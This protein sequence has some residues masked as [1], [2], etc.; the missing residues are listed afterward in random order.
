MSSKITRSRRQCR[1]G[2]GILSWC[3]SAAMW[4]LTWF[5]IT[6]S[7]L[8]SCLRSLSDKRV[9]LMQN[10]HYSLWHFRG[11]SQPGAG[12]EVFAIRL[13]DCDIG[14]WAL[15]GRGSTRWQSWASAS[16]AAI[17]YSRG[18]VQMS[19]FSRASVA[20]YALSGMRWLQS[21]TLRLRIGCWGFSWSCASMRKVSFSSKYS[22][23]RRAYYRLRILCFSAWCSFKAS[24]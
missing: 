10:R 21:S 22:W 11:K 16:K 18:L 19:L 3:W 24:S 9:S 5:Y 13:A 12:S 17:R 7:R 23:R 4:F 6:C 2:Y 1:C 20:R 14:I 8:K 15:V